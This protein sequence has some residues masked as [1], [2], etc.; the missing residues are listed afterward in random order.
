MIMSTVQP[1]GEKLKKAIKY[2]SEMRQ[3]DPDVNLV[4][5]V[6]EAS[7]QYDLSPKDSEF[8][9]RFVNEENA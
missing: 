9:T 3:N 1:Q 5:L 4:K 8:L 6:D 2:V 7:L